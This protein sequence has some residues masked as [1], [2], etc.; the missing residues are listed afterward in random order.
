MQFFRPV[1]RLAERIKA[2]IS[3]FISCIEPDVPAGNNSPGNRKGSAAPFLVIISA[4]HD[5]Q[6]Q[7]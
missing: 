7:L 3:R 4:N 2:L 5:Q 6:S 1:C